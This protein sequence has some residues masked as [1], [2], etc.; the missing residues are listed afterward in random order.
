MKR[1][2]RQVLSRYEPTTTNQYGE[3]FGEDEVVLAMNEYA[4]EHAKEF[5]VFFG[6]AVKS[7]VDDDW[8]QFKTTRYAGLDPTAMY[9][10]D[11]LYDH[12][13]NHNR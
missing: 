11:S 8:Q 4:C 3:T 5:A 6:K 2:P 1:S 13:E 10:I 9:T 12:F 7:V